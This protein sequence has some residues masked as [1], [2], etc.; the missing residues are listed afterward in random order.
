MDSGTEGSAVEPIKTNVYFDGFNYYYAAFRSDNGM[1]GRFADYKW[2]DLRAYCQAVL[3]ER[4]DINRIR[5]FTTAVKPTASDPDKHMRQDHYLRALK[6]ACGVSV[7]K[8]GQ[9]RLREKYG[10]I[11]EP[12]HCQDRIKVSLREE[13]G[14]DVNLASHLILDA[15][16]GDFD[17]AVV[18]SDDSDLLV[19]VRMVMQTFNK[20]V[21]VI[22]LRKRRC[23]FASV[24]THVYHGDKA[25][26][27]SRN[28]LPRDVVCPDGK[29]LTRPSRW[30]PKGA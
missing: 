25:H 2:L 10:K 29:V 6:H 17:A 9:F 19:P 14:A 24:A 8:D 13:K 5:Y 3:G 28:Q 16:N 26:F 4:F 18:V 7:H 21:Y 22:H 11:V 15:A 30:D 1:P 23:S 27:F 12:G 20:Q